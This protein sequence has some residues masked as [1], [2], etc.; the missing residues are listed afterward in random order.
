MAQIVRDAD[1]IAEQ[2]L[3][4]LIEDTYKLEG[5]L[6]KT[7]SKIR[8]SG[9][10]ISYDRVRDHLAEKGLLPRPRGMYNTAPVTEETERLILKMYKETDMTHIIEATGLSENR[11][12]NVISLRHD[13]D[14]SILA[15]NKD[16][17]ILAENNANP[18]VSAFDMFREMIR[19]SEKNAKVIG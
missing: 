3:N 10:T 18:N 4:K 11:V 2:K 6:T 5:R 17:A 8:S 13:K 7:I 12:R 15:E 9:V 14:M 16:M 19:K 1:G